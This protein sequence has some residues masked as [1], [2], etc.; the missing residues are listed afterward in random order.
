VDTLFSDPI[1]RLAAV[2]GGILV[3]IGLFLN[4]RIAQV[5]L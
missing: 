2:G 3:A 5:E 4:H 1:G